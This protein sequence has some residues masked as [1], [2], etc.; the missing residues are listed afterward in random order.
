MC[1]RDSPLASATGTNDT[2]Y[3][4]KTRLLSLGEAWYHSDQNDCRNLVGW[5]AT[6]AERKG[7]VVC[8][9][10]D[11]SHQ[12]APELVQNFVQSTR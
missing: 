10:D 11:Q 2:N 9:G 5:D 3:A 4:N 12:T 1:I 6:D 8:T 7:C